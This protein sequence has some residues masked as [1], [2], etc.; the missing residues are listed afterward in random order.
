M[1][2]SCTEDGWQC[3]D[4]ACVSE[5]VHQGEV[6]FP[7]EI[8]GACGECV[9]TDNGEVICDDVD[10]PQPLTC[11]GKDPG[12][13][14]SQGCLECLCL[15]DDLFVCL[16]TCSEGDCQYQGET[17][18]IGE[19]FGDCDECTCTSSGAV[20]LPVDCGWKDPDGFS[21]PNSDE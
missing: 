2:C 5:C 14:I 1:Q 7:G 13:I 20:C 4:S 16:D 18:S 8:F 9:C 6:Y 3:D 21:T 17:Y 12:T 11:Q 10:C 15:A 19:V